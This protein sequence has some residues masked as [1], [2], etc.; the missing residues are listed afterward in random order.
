M[1]KISVKAPV[2][3]R[4]NKYE[5]ETRKMLITKIQIGEQKQYRVYRWMKDS[6]DDEEWQDLGYMPYAWQGGSYHGLYSSVMYSQ[7]EAW[8][9]AKPFATE[10]ING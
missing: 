1:K 2:F 6:P 9:K 8:A 5:T 7:S 4:S 10:F 3:G